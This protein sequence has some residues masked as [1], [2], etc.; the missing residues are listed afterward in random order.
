[1]ARIIKTIEIEGEPA[2]ALFD[3][4]AVHTYVREDFVERALRRTVAEPFRVALGG[5]RF[6]VR[7]FCLMQGRI[8]G[9]S[10]DTKIWRSIPYQVGMHFPS[11]IEL[12]GEGG[13]KQWESLTLRAW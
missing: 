11:W 4:G 13:P 6:E 1:M 8:E 3:A 2:V 10:F 7:E 12:S 5:D 9:L